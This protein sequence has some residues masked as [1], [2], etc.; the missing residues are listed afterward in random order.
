MAAT[1]GKFGGNRPA[2]LLF[3]METSYG[4][5]L[6]WVCSLKVLVNFYSRFQDTVLYSIVRR[7]SVYRCILDVFTL[8]FMYIPSYTC[9][10]KPLPSKGLQK[11]S[12][13]ISVG[14]LFIPLFERTLEIWDPGFRGGSDSAPTLPLL[15]IH[16]INFL[17]NYLVVVGFLEL[18]D[19]GPPPF[20]IMA[21]CSQI[22]NPLDFS[23]TIDSII[24]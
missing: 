23:K 13:Q 11:K 14:L 18:L 2:L 19:T 12:L 6:I 20:V 10:R 7:S 4:K 21:R 24:C 17:T 22:Q 15:H 9:E 1:K 3:L 16:S 8:N 5:A